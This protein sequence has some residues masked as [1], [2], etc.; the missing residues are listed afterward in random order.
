MNENV[1]NHQNHDCCKGGGCEGDNCNCGHEYGNCGCHF[2]RR[3]QTKAEQIAT[4]EAYLSHIKL[5]VQA[6]EEKIAD[7]NK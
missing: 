1:K 3:Y 5:E 2:E 7:L 4:L 6:V